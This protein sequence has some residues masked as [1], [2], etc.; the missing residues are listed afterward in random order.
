MCC[1]LSGVGGQPCVLAQRTVFVSRLRPGKR[2]PPAQTPGPSSA[3]LRAAE[4]APRDD[5]AALRPAYSPPARGRAPR[6]SPVPY[7][8]AQARD[9]TTCS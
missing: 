4:P 8:V 7:V 2:F 5:L 6:L 3:H 9:L 1:E